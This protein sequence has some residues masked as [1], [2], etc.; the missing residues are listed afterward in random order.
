LQEKFA[1]KEFHTAMYY[2]RFKAWDSAI[3]QFRNIVATYPRTA[4]V[5]EALQYL[6]HAYHRL[7]YTEDLKETCQYIARFYPD[8]AKRVAQECPASAP[9]AP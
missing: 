7:D 4:I 5:P 3:L 9:G 2:Y 6:V 8:T 1:V